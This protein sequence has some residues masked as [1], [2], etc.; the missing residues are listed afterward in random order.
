MRNRVFAIL[1]AVLSIPAF[2]QLPGA[3]GPPTSISQGMEITVKVRYDND[4][5]SP[6]NLSV[7]VVQEFGGTVDMRSTD[8]TG[9]ATFRNISPGK[10]K[11]VVA[12]AGINKVETAVADLTDGGPHYTQYISVHK[13][14]G[15]PVSTPGG[16]VASAELQIPD[17]AKKEY[18]RGNRSAEDKDWNGA[19][20]HFQKALEIYPKYALAEN[21]LALTY[22]SMGQGAKAVEAF[23]SALQ[24][25]ENLPTANTYLG[26]FYYD[27]HQYKDA[28]P[29]LKRAAEAKPDAQILTALANSELRNGE[30]DQALANAQKVHTIKDHKQFAIA[31]LIAAQVYTDRNQNKEA[32][33]EYEQFLKED[34]KSNLAPAVRDALQKMQASAK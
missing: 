8:G 32:A 3:G 25:D 18:D 27:N 26:Q 15:P 28:E 9:T 13:N 20:E 22:A 1:L 4:R 23:R 33:G 14:D 30:L 10:Y 19:Q 17:K 6:A 34:P 24:M 5:N 2:A 29:Y 7:Q 11:F 12:G 21:G 31:H 16:N